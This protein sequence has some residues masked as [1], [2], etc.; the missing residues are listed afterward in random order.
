[1]QMSVFLVA[2]LNSLG[3]GATLIALSVIAIDGWSRGSWPNRAY[4]PLV[5]AGAALLVSSPAAAQL[6]I[7]SCPT[8]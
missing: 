7:F 1:M 6:A 8:M 3:M 5:H 2:A 4:A